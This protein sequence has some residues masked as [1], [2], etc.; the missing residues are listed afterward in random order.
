MNP[1]TSPIFQPNSESLPRFK[2]N[3]EGIGID[4][5]IPDT[6]EVKE[7]ELPNLNI[8]NYDNK[9][10]DLEKNKDHQDVTFF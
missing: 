9:K 2:P 5:Y 3:S 8:V 1:E 7:Q 6:K 10:L 4:D